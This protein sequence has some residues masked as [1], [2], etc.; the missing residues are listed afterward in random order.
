MVVT[1]SRHLVSGMNKLFDSEANLA[2]LRLG[3]LECRILEEVWSRRSL[4]VRELLADGKIQLAYT[5]VMTTLDRLF[6]K[7]LL[8]RTEEGKAFRYSP[9]CSPAEVPRFVAVTGMQRWIESTRPSSLL[10]SYFV[11]AISCHDARLLDELK[12]L[13]NQKRSELKKRKEKQ[14]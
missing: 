4:T 6:K 12:V 7:G 2:G 11:E 14:I 3:P 10:L 13:V 5:T 8:D 1:S 9:R